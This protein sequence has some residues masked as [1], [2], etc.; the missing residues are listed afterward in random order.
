MT[1]SDM[2]RSYVI[3]KGNREIRIDFGNQKSKDYTTIV[4]AEVK[5]NKV[6]VI[7]ATTL[8]KARKWDKERINGYLAEISGLEGE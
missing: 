8:G 2:Q 5:D 1:D 7:S 3:N 6:T 4:V